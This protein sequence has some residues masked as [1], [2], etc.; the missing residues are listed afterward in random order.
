[1]VSAEFGDGVLPRDFWPGA[2]EEAEGAMVVV[3]EVLHEEVELE[4][5]LGHVAEFFVGFG[6]G[7]F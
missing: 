6:H 5:F 7:V 1:V 4:F 3:F 2:F